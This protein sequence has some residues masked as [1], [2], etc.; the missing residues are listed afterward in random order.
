M[1][2]CRALAA[3]LLTAGGASAATF[4]FTGGPGR[5][6]SAFSYAVDGLSLT[7]S[8]AVFDSTGFRGQGGL[9]GDWDTGLGLR[10]SRRDSHTLDGAGYDE[11]LVFTFSERVRL[12][13]VSFSYADSDD[14]FTL[15][16]EQTG[17]FG[18]AGSWRLSP[19]GSIASFDFQTDW[20]GAM[21]GIGA[22]GNND[23]FKLRSIS[24]ERLVADPGDTAVVPLPPTLALIAAA[25]AGL[26][27]VGR[28]RA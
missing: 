9:V 6:S 2:V 11:L 27:L 4:D 14:D 17:G 20:L 12:S 22:A 15:F 28:R 19:T 1:T 23:E 5:E 3:F 21:F 25:M 13:S 18:N 26:A 7:V 10:T 8:G 24:V 16:A